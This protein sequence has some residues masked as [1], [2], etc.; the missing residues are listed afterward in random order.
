ML[1]A[2]LYFRDY[3]I[4]YDFVSDFEGLVLL[5]LLPCQKDVI[6]SESP[7][8]KL[9][10][11]VPG[12]AELRS[13]CNVGYRSF[14]SDLFRKN[15]RPDRFDVDVFLLKFLLLWVILAINIQVLLNKTAT[16][17]I[18]NLIC[19]KV[20]QFFNELFLAFGYHL[21]VICPGTSYYSRIDV[22]LCLNLYLLR[23]LVII[24]NLFTGLV[25]SQ[26]LYMLL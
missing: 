10:Q 6:H 2:C 22:I 23:V 7:T 17:W 12:K 26:I 1:T 15:Y 24:F 8:V 11:M 9:S 14:G 13:G 3:L 16:N 20:R 19:A 4:V 18:P 5:V 21:I 25:N